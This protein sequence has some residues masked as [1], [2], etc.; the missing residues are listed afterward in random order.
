MTSTTMPSPAGADPRL[1]A[2]IGWWVML[3]L[4][5]LASAHSV[6]FMLGLSTYMGQDGGQH[7]RMFRDPVLGAAHTLG[8]A[9]AMIIGP[10]QFLDSLR[11][12]HRRLHV[13]LGRIY[14]T[15]VGAGAVAGLFLSPGSLAADTLGIAFISLALAWLYTGAHAYLAIRRRDIEAH[16]RW[17]VRNYALTYAA[18]TLRIEM[19]LLMIV[20]GMGAIRALDVVGWLCWLPNLFVVETIMGRRALRPAV[21]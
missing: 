5:I 11:R 16:K 2:R 17:M 3:V 18:V 20:F 21:R 13:W 7:A 10:F 6:A 8:G 12:N 4:A 19:P 9:I 15:S 14:L 1:M